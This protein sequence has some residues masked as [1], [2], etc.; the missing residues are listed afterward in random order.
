MSGQASSVASVSGGAFFWNALLFTRALR[1]EGITTDLGAAIDYSRALTFIDIGER[2]QVR[3]AG[4]AIFVRRRDEVPVYDEVFARFWQR[5]ELAI[6]PL[7]L[8]IAVEGAAG[9]QQQLSE[10]A[11]GEEEG[12][13]EAAA[14]VAEGADASDQAGADLE[15]ETA[16]SRSWSVRPPMRLR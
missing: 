5:Y 11:A 15:D 6:E 8:E 13:E 1:A 10:V 2:E 7:D 9:E 3:A 12:L 16:G 4:M 14:G